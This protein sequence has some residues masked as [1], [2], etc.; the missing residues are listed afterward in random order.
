MFP[1][2][3]I[4]WSVLKLCL[5]T[6]SSAEGFWQEFWAT[7]WKRLFLLHAYKGPQKFSGSFLPWNPDPI[8][9]WDGK[10]HSEAHLPPAESSAKLGA[11]TAIRKMRENLEFNDWALF[12]TVHYGIILSLPS[13][14][15]L[16]RLQSLLHVS[17]LI[18]L[19]VN[20]FWLNPKIMQK[21]IKKPLWVF[22]TVLSCV[23]SGKK[24]PSCGFLSSEIASHCKISGLAMRQ[25]GKAPSFSST[26]A[27]HFCSQ[28]MV[29]CWSTTLISSLTFARNHKTTKKIWHSVSLGSS[30]HSFIPFPRSSSSFGHKLKTMRLVQIKSLQRWKSLQA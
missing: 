20:L 22:K 25:A 18:L 4:S 2:I 24:I 6:H 27:Q 12:Y 7:D 23:L 13:C 8:L 21:A 26:G 16:S 29:P 5:I 3:E 9:H 19:P 10:C 28:E 11:I 15:S 30:I 14:F 17:R 1:Y